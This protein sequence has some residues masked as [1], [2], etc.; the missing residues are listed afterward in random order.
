MPA[1]CWLVSTGVVYTTMLYERTIYQLVTDSV[2]THETARQWLIERAVPMHTRTPAGLNS[3]QQYVRGKQAIGIGHDTL[4]TFTSR[5]RITQFLLAGMDY[6]LVAFQLD[7]NRATQIVRY[8]DEGFSV[9]DDDYTAEVIRVL[10]WSYDHPE[11]A[12]IGY[13]REDV[14]SSLDLLEQ[15]G[16]RSDN[17]EWQQEVNTLVDD[18]R[19]LLNLQQVWGLYYYDSHSYQ[20]YLLL[21]LC[22]VRDNLPAL[23][24]EQQ[25]KVSQALTVI[26]RYLINLSDLKDYYQDISE[27][28]GQYFDWVSES[29]SSLQLVAWVP[30]EEMSRSTPGSLGQHLSERFQDKYLAVGVGMYQ[31]EE[32]SIP[33]SL[34]RRF[35]GVGSSEEP[36]NSAYIIDLRK[37]NLS[38][39]E[40]QWLADRMFSRLPGG[41]PNLAEDF[42]IILL[43]NVPDSSVFR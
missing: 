10:E 28:V 11:V 23:D 39:E 12:L 41:S 38:P 33:L 5:S 40:M 2:L 14:V 21:K 30:N 20:E 31:F 15:V 29:D 13:G 6:P 35:W 1:P 17:A 37:E 34:E 24:N 19:K 36:G 43:I 9:L 26:N 7:S 25:L 18:V 3:L 16:R 22:S 27:E 4:S 42:D 8:L 32:E